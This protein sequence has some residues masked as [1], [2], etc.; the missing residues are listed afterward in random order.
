MTMTVT[1]RILVTYAR[2]GVEVAKQGTNV[3][4]QIYAEIMRS[5]KRQRKERLKTS[6]G[7]QTDCLATITVPVMAA[8]TV[9]KKVVRIGHFS[10]SFYL[11]SQYFL[12]F[13]RSNQEQLN[14]LKIT[15]KEN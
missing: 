14:E 10:P 6:S 11:Q 9:R 5:L 15:E 13:V 8:V 12:L 4:L 2:G 7:F 3:L 1:A